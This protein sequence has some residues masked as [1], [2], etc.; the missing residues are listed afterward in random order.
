MKPEQLTE[1]VLCCTA[2]WV[3]GYA[4]FACLFLPTQATVSETLYRWCREYPIIALLLGGVLFHALW[5]LRGGH[6]P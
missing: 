4:L 2:L 3:G 6:C 1:I 5:P